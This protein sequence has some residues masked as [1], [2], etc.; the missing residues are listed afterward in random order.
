MRALQRRDFLRLSAATAGTLLTSGLA[1]GA[2]R[3]RSRFIFI[4]LRG[5][6]DGLT[7]VPP[8]ADPHYAT[9]RGEEALGVPGATGGA[10]RLDALFGLHPSLAFLSERFS[11]RELVV[12]HAIASPYRERSHFDGQDVL[13]NEIG[14]A[15]CRERV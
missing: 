2:G 5:A 15:S 9:L 14:R 6:L 13:E 7:A 12:F 8:Y 4:I 1:L 10:L 3:T 11:A